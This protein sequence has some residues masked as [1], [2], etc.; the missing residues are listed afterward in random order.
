MQQKKRKKAGVAGRGGGVGVMSAVRLVAALFVV[1]VIVVLWARS[2]GAHGGAAGISGTCRRR[3]RAGLR[4]RC[5]RCGAV[6]WMSVG[7]LRACLLLGL[8]PHRLMAVWGRTRRPMPVLLVLA[9]TLVRR[10]RLL[11]LALVLARSG[12]VGWMRCPPV[13]LT[14][15]FR[16]TVR[17][18]GIG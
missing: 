7:V 8:S 18:T 11:L 6:A 3:V 16:I 9:A 10:R 5:V 12:C 1:A 2:V 15:R 14:R 4:H 17:I 13:R